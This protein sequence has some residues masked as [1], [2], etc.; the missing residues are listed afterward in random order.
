[1]EARGEPQ[2]VAAQKLAR[3][4]RA[5]AALAPADSERAC[6]SDLGPR[7]MVVSS[8]DGDLTGAV[9]D[10]YGCRDVRLTDD[11]HETPP[12]EDDQGGVVGGVLQGGSALLDALGVGRA[13]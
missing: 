6:T 4:Q 12:G 11:P 2:P 5:L 9:V 10:D 3:L 13:H 7:W 1:M 8:H